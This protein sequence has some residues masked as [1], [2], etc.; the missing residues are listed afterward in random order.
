MLPV[1]LIVESMLG[2]ETIN[3]TY[4]VIPLSI[5]KSNF[6]VVIVGYNSVEKAKQVQSIA[7]I[8]YNTKEILKFLDDNKTIEGYFIVEETEHSKQLQI[9]SQLESY[10]ELP[11]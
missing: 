5:T 1:Q 11:F 9:I 6:T 2:K 3:H 7:I 4:P 10:P 8:N